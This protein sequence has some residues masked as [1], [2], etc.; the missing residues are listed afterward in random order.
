MQIS[1]LL[2]LRCLPAVPHRRLRQAERRLRA[3]LKEVSG[4]KILAGEMRF[5]GGS[6]SLAKYTLIYNL[7]RAVIR[8]FVNEFGEEAVSDGPTPRRRN[9]RSARHAV[10]QRAVQADVAGRQE[11][12]DRAETA[13]RGAEVPSPSAQWGAGSFVDSRAGYDGD[14]DDGSTVGSVSTIADETFEFT[15]TKQSATPARF[16]IGSAGGSGR[17]SQHKALETDLSDISEIGRPV[18]VDHGGGMT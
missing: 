13:A 14:M 3:A 17:G 18:E 15:P 1:A 9:S 11:R 7:Q 4:L 10:R 8:A 12:R 16:G 2:T 5:N 6:I